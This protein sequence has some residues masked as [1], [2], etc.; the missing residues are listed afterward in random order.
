[1]N[2][3]GSSTS[4]ASSAGLAR[5]GSSALT[6]RPGTG[7]KESA[8]VTAISKSISP[9]AVTVQRSHLPWRAPAAGGA[10]LMTD[11]LQMKGPWR[12]AWASGTQAW[13]SAEMSTW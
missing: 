2:I 7:L 11:Q 8:S 9:G 1:M 10:I 12:L 3:P 4:L 5:D 6:R 13:P